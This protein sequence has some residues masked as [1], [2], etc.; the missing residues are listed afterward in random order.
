LNKKIE[1]FRAVA[2][3]EHIGLLDDL[4][5]MAKAKYEDTLADINRQ[6]E[7]MSKYL[8]V[9]EAEARDT[10]RALEDIERTGKLFGKTAEEIKAAQDALIRF[11]EEAKDAE[12]Q[13]QLRAMGET[14][15][16]AIGTALD[17]IITKSETAEQALR[18]LVAQILTLIAQAAILSLFDGTGFKFNVQSLLGGGGA[19]SFNGSAGTVVRIYNQS[20]GGLVTSSTRSNGDTDVIIGQMASAINRGG[21]Q[22]DSMLR[23]TYGLRRQGV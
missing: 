16:S 20:A 19:K 17:S 21:N 23:R 6:W 1:T 7:D 15:G 13:E 2:K 11:K 4:K 8:S 5:Q 12:W 18:K 14:V 3:P 9:T 10:T 22:F